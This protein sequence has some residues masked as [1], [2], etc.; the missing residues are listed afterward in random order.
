MMGMVTASLASGQTVVKPPQS[1]PAPLP[2]TRPAVV[3]APPA[4]AASSPQPEPPQLSPLPPV[5]PSWLEKLKAEDRAPLDE[6]RAYA[7]PALGTNLT[8][9]PER[10][11]AAPQVLS[12]NDL[13]G[14][15]VVL[16]S[17]TTANLPGRKWLERTG[18]ALKGFPAKD[19]RVI[20]LHTPEN[21]ERAADFLNKQ[22]PPPGVVVA[23]DVKG[24][25]C[26]AL[27][28][29]KAPV[30]IVIDRQGVVRF[31]GLN[32]RGLVKAV[33]Q[34]TQE[35]FDSAKP[36]PMR[37][38]AA[39]TAK[40]QGDFPPFSGRVQYAEDFRGKT[41]PDFVADEWITRQPDMQGKVVVIDFWA[42]WCKPCVE[43]IPHMNELADKFG[44]QAAFIGLSG[45]RQ[46]KFEEG[47]RKINRKPASFHYGLALDPN[48]SMYKTIKITGIPHCIV[49]SSDWIV[50]WQGM[51]GELNEKMLEQI[52]KADAAVNSRQKGADKNPT[53]KSR[54]RWVEG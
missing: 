8:W 53:G 22:A 25:T 13:R 45:E 21:A 23:I 49:I 35:K 48:D 12:W 6:L 31:V 51:P 18:M 32:D 10:P 30:N 33:A 19:L 40:E 2:A 3:A 43:A 44:D 38:A 27:G 9:L 29:Y 28:M 39:P 52:I 16:Q 5:D 42:T 46:I 47:L 26:D 7:P 24:T 4:P 15:V 11:G 41:A 17:F 14:R 37:I 20:V 34:L 54:K 1:P 36:P 50:R